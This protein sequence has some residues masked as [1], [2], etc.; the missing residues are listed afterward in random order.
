MNAVLGLRSRD[1]FIGKLRRMKPPSPET[2]SLPAEAGHEGSQSAQVEK[3]LMLNF[4][5]KFK[6]TMELSP[7][8]FV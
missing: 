3:I 4:R 8:N 6:N 2:P 1:N 5:E 7:Q